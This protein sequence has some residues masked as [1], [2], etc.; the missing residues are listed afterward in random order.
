[1][2]LAGVDL[3][4]QYALLEAGRRDDL[5][6]RELGPIHLV[7]YAY[8]ADLAHAE[9]RGGETFTGAPWKFYHYG[10]WAQEVHARIAPA[11]AAIDA[12]KSAGG[13]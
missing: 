4:V 6:D 9:R 12:I 5:F 8:L 1:M 2:N 3:V 13:A 11:L 10:P 7:K